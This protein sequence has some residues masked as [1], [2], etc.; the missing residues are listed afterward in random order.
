MDPDAIKKTAIKVFVECG[1]KQFEMRCDPIEISSYNNT[2]PDPDWEYT[3]NQGHYH[4]RSSRKDNHYP[5]LVTVVDCEA[6]DDYNEEWHYECVICGE[7]IVPGYKDDGEI[8]TF[9]QGPITTIATLNDGRK[10]YL[11]YEQLQELDQLSKSK[12]DYEFTKLREYLT[13]LKEE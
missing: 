5:T 10:I 13:K 11:N 1:F 12:Y 7:I 8:R 4:Y 2:Y 9:I 3:D 6:T